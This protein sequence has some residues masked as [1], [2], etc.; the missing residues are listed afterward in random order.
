MSKVI[1]VEGY[2]AAGKSTF[3][4]QLSKAINV[5]YLIK[6]TFKIALCE[7]TFVYELT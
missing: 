2:L 7:S 5:P 6:D 4:R 3:T 1:V